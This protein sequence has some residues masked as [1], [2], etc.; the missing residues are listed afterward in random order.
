MSVLSCA[1]GPVLNGE[2]SVATYLPNKD[3]A[4][5]YD[6]SKKPL[7]ENVILREQEPSQA[8]YLEAPRRFLNK[9]FK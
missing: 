4:K 8:D 9:G 6:I 2:G 3:C 7:E 1:E 5:F